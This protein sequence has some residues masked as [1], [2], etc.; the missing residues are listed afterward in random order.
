MDDAKLGQFLGQ[1]SAENAESLRLN[2]ALIQKID[3][4][5][6][7]LQHLSTEVK[8]MG[9]RHLQLEDEVNEIKPIV[10]DYR[11]M[12]DRGFGVIAFIGLV[13]AGFGA[14]AV[15]LLSKLTF[16]G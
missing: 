11:K 6:V 15:S 12:K 9:E 7:D 5:T 2:N 4:L 16:N 14:G 3:A 13:S 10:E 1:L 8:L